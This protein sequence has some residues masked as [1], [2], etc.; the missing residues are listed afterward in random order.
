MES[1][2][3]KTA[4]LNKLASKTSHGGS[5]GDPFVNINQRVHTRFNAE[6]EHILLGTEN[7]VQEGFNALKQEMLYRKQLEEAKI[8]DNEK[9]RIRKI[10]AGRIKAIQEEIHN[11]TAPSHFQN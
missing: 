1:V 2:I 11:S 9:E 7:A 3:S 6:L 4:D 10:I 8:S 5:Q